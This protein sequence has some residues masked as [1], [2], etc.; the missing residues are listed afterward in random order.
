MFLVDCFPKMLEKNC[1]TFVKVVWLNKSFIVN[2]SAL[3]NFGRVLAQF[4][5]CLVLI[6][7]ARIRFVSV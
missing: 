1:L 4:R 5:P 3:P 2:V 7:R 6:T